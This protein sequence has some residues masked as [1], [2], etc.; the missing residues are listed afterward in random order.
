LHRFAFAT[1]AEE[2]RL[3]YLPDEEEAAL[4]MAL[5]SGALADTTD[6]EQGDGF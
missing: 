1:Q 4:A 2:N 5:G 3:S 6:D